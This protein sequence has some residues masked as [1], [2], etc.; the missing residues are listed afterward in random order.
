MLENLKRQEAVLPT[1]DRAR[2]LEL[3]FELQTLY[4]GDTE[5]VV[6]YGDPAYWE[7]L[8]GGLFTCCRTNDDDDDDNDNNDPAK[9]DDDHTDDDHKSRNMSKALLPSH[10]LQHITSQGYHV[11]PPPPRRS[12]QQSST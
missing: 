3:L 2:T 6:K 7:D 11:L 10:L 5:A 8:S 9:D 12:K 4:F 1:I